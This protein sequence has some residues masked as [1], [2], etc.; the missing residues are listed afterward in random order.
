[1]ST[2]FVALPVTNDHVLE[3]SKNRS[4][5]GFE[6]QVLDLLQELKFS[7]EHGGHY[8]DPATG[9]DRQFDIRA[10]RYYPN[11]RLKICLSVECKNLSEKNPLAVH[12][13]QRKL[14]DS[15]H[16]VVE[17]AMMGSKKI[18]PSGW[19]NKNEWV[20]KSLDNVRYYETA[21]GS[22]KFEGGDGESQEKYAQ[23]IIASNS[24]LGE[25]HKEIQNKWH[26][27]PNERERGIIIPILVVP[28]G[29]LFEIQY[30]PISY[31]P[32]VVSTDKTSFFLNIDI[33]DKHFKPDFHY[34]LSHLEIVT[35]DGLKIF[36][37]SL[38]RTIAEDI[39]DLL[40]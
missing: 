11:S 1:M 31:E 30:N 19:Y 26:E 18:M 7:C 36:K 37:E 3:F 4:D 15:Y 8:E 33:N 34:N 10:S 40:G 39:E 24:Y 12:C 17:P 13:V 16:S 29:R 6:L 14:V 5:F 20:G 2:K 21:D 25:L 35:V 9:K 27:R 22:S 28:N 38:D 32:K 23:A